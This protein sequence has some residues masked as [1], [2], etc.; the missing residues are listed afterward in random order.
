MQRRSL[1]VLIIDEDRSHREMLKAALLPLNAELDM[2]EI[3]PGGT[4]LAG[5]SYGPSPSLI[6]VNVPESSL[7]GASA[8]AAMRLLHP[9]TPMIVMA[10]DPEVLQIAMTSDFRLPRYTHPNVQPDELRG[11]I[12]SILALEGADSTE[13]AESPG[14]SPAREAEPAIPLSSLVRLQSLFP[15]YEVHVSREGA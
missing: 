14:D 5:K 7:Y 15:G 12:R 4:I 2:A 1:R 13:S 8:L 9:G 11:L 6:L 3:D 10:T